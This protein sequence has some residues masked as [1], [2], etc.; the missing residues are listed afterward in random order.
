MSDTLFF[1]LNNLGTIRDNVCFG[2]KGQ[3]TE[4][5]IQA[6]LTLANAQRFISNLP[7]GIDSRRLKY[8]YNNKIINILAEVGEKGTQMSGG[9]KQRIAIARA[10]VRDPKVRLSPI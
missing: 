1:Y 10:L 4:E 5:Q 9:Q 2:V 3:V 7:A 8:L 6:A